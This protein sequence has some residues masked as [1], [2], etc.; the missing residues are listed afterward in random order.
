[1]D[2]CVEDISKSDHR[3]D[4]VEQI[5]EADDNLDM[6]VIF[7]LFEPCARNAHELCSRKTQTHECICGCHLTGGDD[8]EAY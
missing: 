6:P 7:K 1:M 3:S 8:E 4:G 5:L 2:G